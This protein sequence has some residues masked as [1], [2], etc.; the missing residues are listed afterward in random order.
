MLET[1]RERAEDGLEECLSGARQA[2]AEVEARIAAVRRCPEE[3]GRYNVCTIA[4][5]S[6]VPYK[7]KGKVDHFAVSL[8]EEAWANIQKSDFDFFPK[9]VIHQPHII[10]PAI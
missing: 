9:R 4:H 3:T 2:E 10:Y 5:K 7:Y 1:A 8:G 6:I